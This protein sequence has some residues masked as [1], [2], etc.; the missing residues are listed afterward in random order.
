VTARRAAVVF[1]EVVID[2]YPGEEVIAGAA[3]HVAA[4]LAGAGWHTYLVTRVGDDGAGRD[5]VRLIDRLGI[6]RA[7]VEHDPELPTG[8]STVHTTGLENAFTVLRP[9]AW[10]EIQGPSELPPH[11]AV[12]YGTLAARS[13][14][15]RAALER[16]LSHSRARHK[17]LDVN[18]RPPD[19]NRNVIELALGEAS[20]VKLSERELEEVAAN[21]GTSGHPRSLF[22]RSP[23]LRWVCV[24]RG[25][26][27]A[28]LFDRGGS[29]WENRPSPVQV[30]NT[31]GAGDAFTAGLAEGLADGR[32]P[33]RILQSAHA[34][35]ASILTKKGAL[36]NGR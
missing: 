33:Q 7:F 2:V 31:V 25:D 28:A 9:A 36:P 34:R 23:R 11:D 27:G 24:T 12:C 8:R 5:I 1:G 30:V 13:P 18:L 3:L 22:Q 10:D 26:Q 21:L 29:C 4:H 32:A 20:A 14:T 35:A 6:D 16:L 19:V 15:S 17:V